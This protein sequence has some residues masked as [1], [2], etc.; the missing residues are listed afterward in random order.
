[1]TFVL[2]P[3]FFPREVPVRAPPFQLKRRGWG[4]FEVGVLVT[5]HD[6]QVLKFRHSLSFS[7]GQP[8]ECIYDVCFHTALLAQVPQ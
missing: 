5:F 8:A 1:V 2:H 7:T 6:G 4:V 3:T